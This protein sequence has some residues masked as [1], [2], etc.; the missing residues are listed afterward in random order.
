MKVAI[1]LTALLAKP[2]GVDTYLTGLVSSLASLDRKNQYLLFLN[3]EDRHRFSVDLEEDNP[4]AIPFGTRQ[5]LAPQS[6]TACTLQLPPN[7]RILPLSLR[8]RPARLFF[9][10]ILQPLVLRSLRFD[11]L[12]SPTFVMP[13][14]RGRQR[15]LL[16]IHDMTS[17]LLPHMHPA[18]RRG[19]MYELAL[20]Q[21]IRRADLVSVPSPSVKQDILDLV[22]GISADHVRVIPCGIGDRFHPRPP[23]EIAPVLDRLGIRW[24]Y[25][26]YV[27][28]LDPRKNLGR[29]V[30]SYR[31]LLAESKPA[32][33][34][35]LAGQPGWNVKALFEHLQTPDLQGRVHVLG[36]VSDA[37]LPSLYA[38][39]R[40]FV[41]PSLAEG[42]GFPPLEAMASG[43]PV[44]A[45]ETSSLKD[46]L[47]GAAELVAAGDV[48]ALK[49]AIHRLLRDH[50]R[51][52]DLADRGLER[53]AEF[54]WE[55]FGRETLNCYRELASRRRSSSGAGA[56]SSIE[57]PT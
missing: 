41:Y 24:P 43:V 22:P 35:V 40:L 16:T 5:A 49:A 13:V 15:H 44:I 33:H 20:G 48:D 31:S 38:G 57:A 30:A 14:Y 25:I 42:F 18:S 39:A 51:R 29:V 3:A 50:R 8:L 10:Q 19:R 12:H 21:S 36:Y 47:A 11:V 9:Q 52:A 53:A 55:R 27:G 26:L 1:D 6:G 37:A 7:F 23:V 45:S 4:P 2:T 32:E 54:R 34:L 17:F 46:N 28:T 56:G